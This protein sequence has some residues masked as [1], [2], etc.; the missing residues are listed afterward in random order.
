MCSKFAAISVLFAAALALSSK[1][2]EATPSY[3]IEQA[4]DLAQERNPDIL[5]AQKKV[6]AA[7]GGFIEARSGY[8]PWLSSSGLYDKRQT[9]SETNLRQE[10]YNAILKLEQNLYTGGGATS[11]GANL[12]T[13]N[14]QAHYD[15]QPTLCRVTID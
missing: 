8:L 5:I 9:Q 14:A 15:R 11:H 10:D 1:S 12:Q 3:T 7:R 13:K 6:M 2:L 4:V